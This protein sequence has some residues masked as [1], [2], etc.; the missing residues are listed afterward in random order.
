MSKS[1]PILEAIDETITDALA[2]GWPAWG[3]VNTLRLVHQ[4][5]KKLALLSPWLAA[6]PIRTSGAPTDMP[7]IQPP[8][9]LQPA[10][11]RLPG[12]GS[13]RIHAT[14]RRPVTLYNPRA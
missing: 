12:P 1:N 11:G 2:N 8:I 9:L 14:A 5:G 13:R 4:F 10:H 6:R 3:E 7:K